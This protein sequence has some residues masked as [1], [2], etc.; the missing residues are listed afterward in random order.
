MLLRSF[1]SLPERM[2]VPVVEAYYG[3]LSEKRG[4]LFAKRLF[5]VTV[6]A[7][8][9]LLLSPLFLALSLYVK[10]GS[11][12]GAFFCQKR[13][14]RNLSEFSI[15]KFRTM[16]DDSGPKGPLLTSA[17]DG[18][19]T[20]AGKRL[21]KSR[22]DELPQLLNVLK[23]DMSFVGTRPEVPAYV[24]RY[25]DEMLATLLLPAGIT[26]EASIRYRNEGEMLKRAGDA[27]AAYVEEILPG[28]MLLNLA[29]LRDYS[30]MSDMKILLK[31]L[32]GR[33]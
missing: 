18:R 31:T 23:G 7:L 16:Y 12:G 6:S 26:S 28:K 24:E 9:L 20:K 11:K 2:R 30:F 4:E 14:T 19:V 29:Y 3:M 17:D 1:E 32:L 21:R 13:V 25:T 10:A 8:L 5:D 33:E 27:E 15:Y 22:L